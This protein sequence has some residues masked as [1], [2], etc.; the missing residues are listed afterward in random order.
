[1]VNSADQ[2]RCLI[3]NKGEISRKE[4]GNIALREKGRRRECTEDGD[5][6]EGQI[7]NRTFE[8]R[9]ERSSKE[10]RESTSNR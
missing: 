10:S 2:M 7:F 4:K 8:L 9:E 1:M 3:E 6:H 5:G